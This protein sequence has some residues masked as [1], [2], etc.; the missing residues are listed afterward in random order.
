MKKYKSS[1][2]KAI[3]YNEMSDFWDTH[4]L[5]KHWKKTKPVSFEVILESEA[6]YYAIDKELSQQVNAVCKERGISADTL[7]NLWVQEKLGEHKI[8]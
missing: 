5:G 8:S 6:T 7:L 1:I 4:D 2:S 3:S